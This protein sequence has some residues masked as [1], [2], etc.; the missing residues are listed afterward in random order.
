MALEVAI[1]PK[2]LELTDRISGEPLRNPPIPVS[3]P[4]KFSE[5]A[6]LSG[7]QASCNGILSL[8]ILEGVVRVVPVPVTEMRRRWPPWY[9]VVFL[10]GAAVFISYIDR[11]NISV[12]SISMKEQFGGRPPGARRELS[13][14]A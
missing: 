2:N 11:T 9:T 8:R 10:C 13:S 12:A 3:R 7:I 6:L 5:D 1:F 4:G 14:R